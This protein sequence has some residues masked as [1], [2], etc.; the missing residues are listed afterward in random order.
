VRYISIILLIIITP[1]NSQSR[2]DGKKIVKSAIFPGWGQ[3]QMGFNKR[4]DS[5]FKREGILLLTYLG[6]KSISKWNQNT[7]IAFAELH[8]NVN[9]ENK[10][11]LFFVNLG[12]YNTLEDYNQTKDRKRLPSDKYPE[13]E[14]YNWEW[15][16]IENRLKFD[17]I[18]LRSAT[19]SKYADFTIAGLIL[20]RVVSLIDILYL[21]KQKSSFKLESNTN[22]NN[23][24]PYLEIILKF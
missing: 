18:R 15:D 23:G 9:T 17:S 19:F 16:S 20:H 11:Y 2:I 1:L 3:S 5:Y 13:N 21:E 7:Y 24:S 22:F 12:H 4:A 6:N 10:D 14:D 8:S